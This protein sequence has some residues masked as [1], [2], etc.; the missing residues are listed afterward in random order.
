MKASLAAHR[1]ATYAP[2]QRAYSQRLDALTRRS[3][4]GAP[5]VGYVGNTVPVDLITASGARALRLAP[6]AGETARSSAF[7][8][9]FSDAELRHVFGL[10][11]D[12]ALDGLALLVLPRSSESWHKLYLALREAVRIGLKQGG[13]P[14]LLYDLLHTQRRSSRAYGLQRTRELAA[15]LAGVTGR[16]ADAQ[17]LRDAIHQSNQTRRLLQHLQ[18]LRLVGAVSGEQAQVGAGALHFMAPHEGQQALRAWLFALDA[19]HKVLPQGAA[20]PGTPA[21]LPPPRLFVHGAALAHA[22]LHAAVDVLGATVVM[23]DDDWGSGAGMPLIDQT[24]EPIA[25]VFEHVWR[26]V[27]CMRTHPAQPAAAGFLQAQA[28][29]VIDGVIFNIPRPDDYHG[30]Q[31][32]ALRDA[33]I[34]AGLPWTLLRDDL[35]GEPGDTTGHGRAHAQ[36]A[37]FV[38]QLRACA[39]PAAQAAT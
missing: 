37:A 18:A 15:A 20:G 28:R 16:S 24:M 27:P 39:R 19:L 25:A 33:A 30:W 2:L 29:G 5:V 26:D 36:L 23:E 6:L 38:Q 31:F 35:G 34:A 9:G 14:L 10:F 3:A 22:R 8:E 32:P 12:G 1:D 21:P 4:G 11:I 17:A 13:P 7:I